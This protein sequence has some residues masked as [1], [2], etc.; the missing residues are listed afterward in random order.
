MIQQS[1]PWAYT[2]KDYT[3]NHRNMRTLMFVTALLMVVRKW[4]QP[5]CPSPDEGMM[6]LRAIYTLALYSA[7]EKIKVVE[8]EGKWVELEKVLHAIDHTDPIDWDRL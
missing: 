3:T 8:F 1:N 7:V 2:L 5:S 6:E 4:K